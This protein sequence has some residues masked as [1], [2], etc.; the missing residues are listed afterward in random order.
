MKLK[1]ITLALLGAT[2]LTAC[3]NTGS[4]TSATT[5][6]TTAA[7]TQSDLAEKLSSKNAVDTTIDTTDLNPQDWEKDWSDQI[8]KLSAAEQ[9]KLKEIAYY[10]HASKVN[11]DK[12][13][14]GSSSNPE[15]VKRI[16]RLMPRANFEKTFPLTA[17][18]QIIN[19]FDPADV[20]SYSNFLKA[21][22]VLPGYCG[23]FSSY[24][25][26]KTAEMT[27]PDEVCKRMMA[28]TFAHAVQETG[29]AKSD[30]Q[31]DI[32]NKIITAFS[33]VAEENSTPENRRVGPYQETS[34]PFSASGQFAAMVA[35]K[36]YYGRGAK[37]L[38]YTSNYANLSLMLYGNL[39]LVE[40]PDLVAG[41]N[42]LP[43]LSALVYAVQPK[44]GRP[45]IAEVM[46]GNFKKSA[47]GTAA[48]YAKLGFPFTIALVNGGPE[49]KGTNYENTRTRLRSFKYFSQAGKLFTS[50]FTLTDAETNAT[51]CDNINPDDPSIWAASQRYYYFSPADGCTLVKWDS[52][53]PIYGGSGYRQAVC[54]APAPSPTP[55]P[56]PSPTPT[57]A[58]DVVDY[59]GFKL[60]VINDSNKMGIDKLYI[61]DFRAKDQGFN[62]PYVHEA[63]TLIFPNAT[64]SDAAA[65][66]KLNKRTLWI[67]FS[68]TWEEDSETVHTYNCSPFAFT[69]NTTVVIR[70]SS[71]AGENACETYPTD[72]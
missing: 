70:P 27:N 39:L 8:S 66:K 47:Q 32:Q 50:G 54:N 31:V 59:N 52:N 60:T 23:D 69:Q 43:Y 72:E 37:Q 40:D 68:P 13:Y 20:Y 21:A 1:M 22:A 57:P 51:N 64:P 46:D 42:I 28:T 65:L 49:C 35:N 25:G 62:L 26:T 29:S 34:G 19:G 30:D 55:A 9:L 36:Y 67:T 45:S 3:N 53:N 14:P 5:T 48:S 7:S 41:D 33:S 61:S 11:L 56:T 63:E 17:H 4:S 58:P 18:H 6:A 24:P 12:I 2:A 38:S 71:K 10:V 15:N 16:E 44:N